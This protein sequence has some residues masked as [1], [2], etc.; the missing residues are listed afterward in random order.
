MRPAL[1]DRG[2]AVGDHDRGATRQQAAQALLDAGLGVQVHIGGG[3]VEDQD[4]GVG[5]QGTREGE[6]LA[7][8]G[9]ELGAALADLCLVAVGQL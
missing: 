1:A 9:R 7:L 4:A 6:Q 3:L 8:T 5:D 2:E